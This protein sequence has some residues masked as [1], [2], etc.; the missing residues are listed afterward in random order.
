MGNRVF[1]SGCQACG[2]LP[3]EWFLQCLF[4]ASEPWTS[5]RLCGRRGTTSSGLAHIWP[6]GLYDAAEG[7]ALAGLSGR[8]GCAEDL[9]LVCNLTSITLSDPVGLLQGC[10][11]D[12]VHG[13]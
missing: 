8:W 2:K 4:F 5:A 1:R 12:R 13:G 3:L 7:T 10:V 9:D 11:A 6:S